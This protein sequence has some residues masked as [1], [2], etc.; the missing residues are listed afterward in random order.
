[1]KARDT[2]VAVALKYRGDWDRMMKS[3]NEQEKI[4][5][6]YINQV[7]KLKCQVTTIFD[8]DYPQQ[9]KNVHKPPLV[10][11]YYGNLS[12][13]E[14]YGNNVSIVGSRDYSEYGEKMTIDIASGLARKGYNI[15][16]GLALGIDSIAHLSAIRSGGTTTAVLGNGIDFCYLKT[17]EDLYKEIKDKYLV[18]SEYPMN[19]PADPY[20]F[21]IRN[22]IIAGLSKTLVVTE[23]KYNSGS[24]VTALLALQGDSD[25]MCVP[26]EAGTE[27]ECNR[28]IKGGAYLVEGANDV[29]DQMSFIAKKLK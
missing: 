12:L 28:L 15:V 3:I 5:R 14:D 2:L 24:M 1:M 16:S 11:F 8:G 25:V 17:N 26:Y 9:L 27:S 18:I 13:I 21:P 29:L 19:T 22:R 7:A 4:E 20:N 23:A 10:L 6:E